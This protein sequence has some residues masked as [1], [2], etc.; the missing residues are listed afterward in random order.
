MSAIDRVDYIT[1]LSGAIPDGCPF[2]GLSAWQ[3]LC[4]EDNYEGY[5]KGTFGYERTTVWWGAKVVDLNFY[6][7]DGRRWEIYNPPQ[8][9]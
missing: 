3:F 1:P 5:F 9:N 7:Q 4:V 2:T 8:N 6:G